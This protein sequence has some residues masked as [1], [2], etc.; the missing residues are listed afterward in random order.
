MS[1]SRLLSDFQKRFGD[2]S[3]EL[4]HFLGSDYENWDHFKQLILT[5]AEKLSGFKDPE[6]LSECM[7]I[8]MKHEF[9]P[10]F[11]DAGSFVLF[12]N[13]VDK[14]ITRIFFCIIHGIIS[15]PFFGPYCEHVRQNFRMKLGYTRIYS[16][17]I[18][19]TGFEFYDALVEINAHF[20]K[21]IPVYLPMPF[22]LSRLPLCELDVVE[23]RE[24]SLAQRRKMLVISGLSRLLVSRLFFKDNRLSRQMKQILLQNF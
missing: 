16:D 3:A 8:L 1:L 21:F 10:R 17:V 14:E 23:N 22:F 15:H 12:L 20:L 24:S 18:E 4:T 19:Y 11:W 6:L 2:K 9:K 5:V 13:Y 7:S